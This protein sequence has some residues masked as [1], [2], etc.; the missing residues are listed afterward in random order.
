V[1][2]RDQ[3]FDPLNP[4]FNFNSLTGATQ[5]TASFPNV[6][7]DIVNHT[8][9]AYVSDEWKPAAGLTLNLGLR[10]DWQTG[11]WNEDHS[12]S[13][14]PRPLPYVDF[15]SRGDTNN[16]G[17]RA[18][19]AWDLHKDGKSVV[20]AGYGLIFNNITN[21]TNGNE[22]TTLKQ[23]NITINNPSY[24]DPYGGR[25]PASFAS[26]APP[27]ISIMNNELVNAPVSTYSAGYSQALAADLAINL[28]GVYQKGTDW[29]TNE[30][31]NAP[32]TP[33]AAATRPLPVWGNITSVDPAG[34]WTYKAL[35]VRLEKRL[36]HRYQYTLSYTLAKQDSNYGSA[37]TVG[38]NQGGTITDFYNQ[39]LDNGPQPNDRRHALVA[40]G[41]AQLPGDV[42][43][44]LIWNFRTTAPTSMAT[45]RTPTTCPAPR[46]TWATAT[47][48]P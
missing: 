4:N 42:V 17:P 18:G 10:Y 23:N 1:F 27:N 24:P 44:G 41:A 45:A 30:N 9:G 3:F 35:L 25:D 13:E 5:F 38:I 8:Y 14:Y 43:L 20:R 46:R 7:R 26:T 19:V 36:T 28:D 48:A 34:E 37:D 21:A 29:P 2:G 31:I 47:T 16:V 11:V 15:A 22:L 12:Q 33:G 32:T 6:Y 40:S 39:A